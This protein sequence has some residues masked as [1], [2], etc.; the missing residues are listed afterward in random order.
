MGVIY[1]DFDNNILNYFTIKIQKSIAKIEE[2]RKDRP[3]LD[4]LVLI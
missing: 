1:I 4:F 2:T 3:A